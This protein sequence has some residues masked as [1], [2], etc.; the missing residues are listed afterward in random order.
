MS[1]VMNRAKVTAVLRSSKLCSSR[2]VQ[3]SYCLEPRIE[4]S[5]AGALLSASWLCVSLKNPPAKG[6]AK[7][8]SSW[9]RGIPHRVKEA[10]EQLQETPGTPS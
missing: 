7:I 10:A 2:S 5:K 3:I 6:K 8:T 9:L 1:V 4:I